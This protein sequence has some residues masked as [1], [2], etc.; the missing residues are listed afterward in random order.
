[1]LGGVWLGGTDLRGAAA[2]GL[3]TGDPAAVDR[4][5][6]IFRTSTAPWSSTW[7]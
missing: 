5:A 1:V 3:V 4:A 6:A 7:F 2:A